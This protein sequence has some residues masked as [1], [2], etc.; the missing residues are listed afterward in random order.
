MTRFVVFSVDHDE[1]Q[2]SVDFVTASTHEDALGKVLD[3]RQYC[4]HGQAHTPDELRQLANDCEKED[5]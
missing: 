4:C 5:S 2:A 1:Q 3:E